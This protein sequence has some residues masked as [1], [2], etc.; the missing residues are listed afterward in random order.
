MTSFD[1]ETNPH[2]LN[3]LNVEQL[4]ALLPAYRED[5]DKHIRKL[6]AIKEDAKYNVDDIQPEDDT[7]CNNEDKQ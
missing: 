5:I 2:Y 4:K 1:Y 7:K 6:I 3:F